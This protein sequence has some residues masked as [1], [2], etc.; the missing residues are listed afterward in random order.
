MPS[1]ALEMSTQRT[2]ASSLLRPPRTHEMQ[3]TQCLELVC[4]SLFTVEGIPV[5]TACHGCTCTHCVF[6]LS[7]PWA[8]QPWHQGSKGSCR[9][10]MIYQSFQKL[11]LYI[12]TLHSDGERLLRALHTPIIIPRTDGGTGAGSEAWQAWQKFLVLHP[13][14]FCISGAFSVD[15]GLE[16]RS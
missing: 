10:F 3:S 5:I 1:W 12:I 11:L 4:S 8:E 7:S 14:P 2:R 16:V 15:P 13:A 6:L 9:A